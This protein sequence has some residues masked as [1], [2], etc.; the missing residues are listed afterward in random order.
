VAIA[1]LAVVLAGPAAAAPTNEDK[2]RARE[3]YQKGITHYDIKEY[4]EALVEFKN[5]YRLVPDPAFL[6]NIAQCYRKL[7]SDVEA[8]DFYRNFLRR[9]PTAPNR[10]EVERRIQELERELETHPPTEPRPDPRAKNAVAPIVPPPAS[11][12]GGAGPPALA[13]PN[14]AE[15]PAIVATPQGGG[16]RGASPIYGRWWFWT[17]VGAVVVAAGATLIAV[18]TRGEVGDCRGLEPCRTVGD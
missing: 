3:H 7:G 16:D 14:P 17:A 15:A 2:I 1:V 6:Y 8:L 12:A 11:G 9:F 5:A 13:Q 18:A 10:S 4:A